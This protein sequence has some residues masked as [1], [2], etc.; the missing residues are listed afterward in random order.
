MRKV[1]LL[2]RGDGHCGAHETTQFGY[3][4]DVHSRAR[5]L[6]VSILHLRGHTEDTLLRLAL[7]CQCFRL[8]FNDDQRQPRS[9]YPVQR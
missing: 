1:H 6:P 7:S 5:E 4:V 2:T 8:P 3:I 9:R